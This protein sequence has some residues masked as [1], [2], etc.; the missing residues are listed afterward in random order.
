MSAAERW[1]EDAFVRLMKDVIPDQPMTNELAAQEAI[2]DH[3]S[4]QQAERMGMYE[5]L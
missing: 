2:A 4:E 5:R 1:D 3:R